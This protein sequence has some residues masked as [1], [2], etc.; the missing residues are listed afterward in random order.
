MRETAA[1]GGLFHFDKFAMSG[2][3]TLRWFMRRNEMSG[4][5]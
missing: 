4:V 3:G 2:I 5:G 1:S